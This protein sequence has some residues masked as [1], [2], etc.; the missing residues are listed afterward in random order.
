MSNNWLSRLKRWI[1]GL[2]H[3]KKRYTPPAIIQRWESE[4]K[5]CSVIQIKRDTP[6][7]VATYRI[8]S[9]YVEHHYLITLDYLPE[10]QA[11][12]ELERQLSAKFKTSFRVRQLSPS[13]PHT[14]R[15]GV[16]LIWLNGSSNPIGIWDVNLESIG[17][18]SKLC[19]LAPL[20]A[21]RNVAW[22][23]LVPH[24]DLSWEAKIGQMDWISVL[25]YRIR[26]ELSNKNHNLKATPVFVKPAG[27]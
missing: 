25:E 12:M 27:V 13:N 11:E 6:G 7:A 24:P 14:H 20:R 1:K 23:Q 18:N 5:D 21:V 22:Q 9:R 19:Q 16:F 3:S 4:T 17:G 26:G 8:I 10:L 15:F 2:F